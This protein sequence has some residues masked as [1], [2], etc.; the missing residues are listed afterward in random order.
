MTMRRGIGPVAAV[1]AALL[2]AG[3]GGGRDDA[4][5]GSGAPDTSASVRGAEG[6]AAVTFRGVD[7]STHSIADYKG[8]I[9][10]IN[11]VA[12]WH[13][14]SRAIVEI[15]NEI[16]HK[17]KANVDVIAVTLD[18]RGAQGARQYAQQTGATFDV[19][20]GGDP[21]RRAFGTPGR[22]PTT[23]VLM[24]DSTEFAELEG[25]HR[26]IY[27]HNTIIKMYQQRL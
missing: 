22:L 11:I 13:D 18:D 5:T 23:Y 3:C 12:S 20:V 9:L 4:E 2:A 1:L 24:R 26:Y 27:Y 25:L 14:D 15:M 7:G 19:F 21:V 16:Q 10:V 6:L 17:F 8:R